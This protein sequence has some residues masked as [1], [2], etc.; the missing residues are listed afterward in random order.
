[1][2]EGG[3]DLRYSDPWQHWL[4]EAAAGRLTVVDRDADPIMLT[5]FITSL[6]A[7]Q[8]WP[9]TWRSLVNIN[10]PRIAVKRPQI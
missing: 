9:K 3:I 4:S 1:L 10:S 7:L 8:W 6:I 5:V 2:V